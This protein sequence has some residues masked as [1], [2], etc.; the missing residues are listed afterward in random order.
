MADTA[1]RVAIAVVVIG[2]GV[3]L[4]VGRKT[5]ERSSRV[6]GIDMSSPAYRL[7]YVLGGLVFVVLGVLA[8]VSVFVR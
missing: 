6:V 7:A 5:V 1:G 4:V 8:L 3:W 2:L